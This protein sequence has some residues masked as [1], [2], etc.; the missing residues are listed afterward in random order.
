MTEPSVID[1]GHRTGRSR[2]RRSTGIILFVYG[3][4]FIF[5]ESENFI[6]CLYETDLFMDCG[7]SL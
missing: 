6:L 1:G 4:S 5:L 7:Y 2:S 3:K